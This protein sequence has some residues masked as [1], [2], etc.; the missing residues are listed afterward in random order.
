MHEP[1]PDHLNCRSVLELAFGSFKRSTVITHVPPETPSLPCA[2]A[3]GTQME[4]A[5]EK[6]RYSLSN[7]NL[8]LQLLASPG[9][10]AAIGPRAE[11]ARGGAAADKA[12]GSPAED[13]G[14]PLPPGDVSRRHQEAGSEAAAPLARRDVMRQRRAPGWL[15]T[16]S[17][18]AASCC[19]GRATSPSR[20]PCA[21]RRGPTSWLLAT[22]AK[23]R[24]P[25]GAEPRRAS[26]GCGREVGR[27]RR[28][29]PVRREGGSGHPRAKPR[30]RPGRGEKP[31]R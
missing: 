4:H 18:C 9:A 20:P 29:R 28:A 2:A 22:R 3:E 31:R 21:R 24:C 19:S 30:R 11:A 7:R 26:G 25:G 5:A 15:A 13:R 23:R 16:W 17:R 1:G 10:P 8:K 6:H 14:E 27:R 12:L